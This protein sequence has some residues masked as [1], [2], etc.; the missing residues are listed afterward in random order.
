[1]RLTFFVFALLLAGLPN[2]FAQKGGTLAS[3]PMQ[4]HTTI[5]ETKI[6]IMTKGAGVA[7]V[8]LTDTLTGDRY[9]NILLTEG[10]NAYKDF[11]PLTFDFTNLPTGHVYTMEVTVD[12]Q[13]YKIDRIYRTAR[14]NMT[15]TYRFMVTSCALAVPFGLRWVHPG[16]EDRVYKHATKTEADFNLW[17]GDYLYYFPK[18]YH[19]EEGMSMK[20]VKIRKRKKIAGFCESIPQY[21]IWDDHEYGSNDAIGNFPFKK[22]SLALFTQYWA[23]PSAGT[24]ETP[25]C[26]FKF[27]YLDSEFFMLDDRYHRTLPTDSNPT[28]LGEGQL[29]W[30]K[31]NL[32]QSQ[33]VFKFV[34]IGSQVFNQVTTHECYW[35][36]TKEL[37]EIMQFIKDE[38]ISGVVF[39]T[40]DRHHSELMK[41]DLQVGYPIYEFTCSG[42]TSFRRRTRRTAEFINP[43]RIPGTLAD[44]QNYGRVTI[45]GNTGERV[46]ILEVFN[47]RGKV[48]WEYSINQNEL[49]AKTIGIGVPV[50]VE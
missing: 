25:G 3:G 31:E 30:F 23:N 35:A 15:D 20:W 22:H 28:L 12:S 24:P 7:S 33:A 27:D 14:T 49:Q 5:T 38:K 44:Y 48:I 46:C 4:G 19:S 1:M 11:A 8:T 37:G 26:F 50:K 16:I 45:T 29:A 32:K 39:L 10:K 40:G 6:W 13:H 34:T 2:L 17:I 36:F 41:T 18:N 42:I 21:S 43:S 47:N 9:T